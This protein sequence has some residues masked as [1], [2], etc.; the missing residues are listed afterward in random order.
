MKYQVSKQ[1]VKDIDKLSKELKGKVAEIFH[2]VQTATT[3]NDIKNCKRLTNTQNSYR[4]R[5]GTYRL[6]FILI[7][8]NDHL[9]FQRLLSRGEVYKKEYMELL[10]KK[11]K[12]V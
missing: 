9:A 4:I 12:S 7:V 2:E 6:T 10:K 1:F 8:I 3:V 5:L 11:E